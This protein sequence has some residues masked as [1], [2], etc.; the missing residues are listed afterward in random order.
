MKIFILKIIILV[1]FIVGILCWLGQYKIPSHHYMNTV[2]YFNTIKKEKKEIDIAIYGSSRAYCSYNPKIIDSVLKTR[3]FNFGNDA[4]RVIVS[5]Y[6]LKETLKDIKPKLVV[7]DVYP[8]SISNPV[9]EKALAY[10]MKSYYY[11]NF[12]F[13]KFKSV[14]EVFPFEN[15]KNLIFPAL[16]RNDFKYDLEFKKSNDYI[17]PRQA[18]A[19]EYRGFIGYDLVMKEKINLSTKQIKALGEKVKSNTSSYDKFSEEEISSLVGFIE[20]AKKENAE[21]LLV[22]APYYSAF[23]EKGGYA[24]FHNFIT[25][26]SRE[27][28]FNVLDFNLHWDKIK[29]NYKDFKDKGHLSSI[30]ANKTSKY[31]ADYVAEHYK[32]PSRENDP[33]WRAEQPLNLNSFIKKEYKKKAKTLN[34]S[35]TE[36][37]KLES[38]KIKKFGGDKKLIIKLDSKVTDSILKK[39]KLGFHTFVNEEDKDK[40]AGYSKSKKRDYDAWDFDPE[41]KEIEGEKY[42]IKTLSTPI[43]HYR[44]IKFFLYDRSGYKGLIGETLEIENVEIN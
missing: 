13:D 11:Y 5:K 15:A 44:K 19:S 3:S 9:G 29:Y 39:Y 25:K 30:G 36:D 12:S 10:Q 26:L 7:L 2:S 6:I 18:K 32:L 34:A 37:L 28:N 8:P 41:I 22:V 43:T 33:L 16:K 4:Q 31:L 21:I 14:L 24:E 42:I 20:Y 23:K 17:H 40:L 1:G 27:H 38:F 35:L